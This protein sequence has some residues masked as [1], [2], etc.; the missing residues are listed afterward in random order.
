MPFALIGIGLALAW[1]DY[2]GTANLQGAG[3]LLQQE[4][5]T[6][7]NPFYK[8]AGALII[9]GLIGYIPELRQ[10]AVAMLVLVI[11]SIALA[12]NGA[13]VNLEKAV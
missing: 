11:L 10:F 6:G 9:I 7:N 12:H 4:V 5:F 2:L 1:L 8:W 13:V 3:S